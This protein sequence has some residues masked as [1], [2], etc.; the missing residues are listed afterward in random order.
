MDVPLP[1]LL[2]TELFEQSSVVAGMSGLNCVVTSINI[3]DG[4]YGYNY[5][6]KNMFVLCSAYS[7]AASA[8][9][10]VDLLEQLFRRGVVG[11]AIKPTYFENNAIPDALIRRADALGLPLVALSG[12]CCS[13]AEFITFFSNSVYLR[14]TR[15]IVSKNQLLKIL[16]QE[17]N[18]Q[19]I[20]G[21]VEKISGF[22]NRNVSV[23]FEDECY[24]FPRRS[25]SLPFDQALSD[26]S[27][28]QHFYSSPLFGGMLCYAD[29]PGGETTGH[30]D[31]LGVPIKAGKNNLD[32]IW[33]HGGETPCGGDDAATLDAA[34]LACELGVVQML[35]H[36]QQEARRR[37]VFVESLLAGKL[38]T[39]H[40]MLLMA[41]GVNWRLPLET[42]ILIV[43]C[44]DPAIDNQEIELELSEMF[45]R[46]TQNIIVYPYF[47][48]VIVFAP[49][50]DGADPAFFEN[51]LTRLVERFGR[52]CFR[53]GI[54]RETALKAAN[55]SYAQA[56]YAL[57]IG[58]SIFPERR[59]CFFEKLGIF[60]LYCP[61][62]LPDELRLFCQD[63]L[64]TL[65]HVDAN[66]KL[67]LVKTLEIFFHC[68]QNYSRTGNALYL[69]PN[70]IRYRMETIEKICGVD[71]NEPD[72]I[73]N[74]KT[75]LKLLPIL[76]QGI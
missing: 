6:K 26:C 24:A 55:K 10:Q 71:F 40:E 67:D 64:A 45:R 60:R 13:Y 27:S 63:Y 3:I 62:A 76:G 75:A 29:Q 37:L 30:N 36:Q 33:L 46:Q 68:Q 65:I 41:K 72:D 66:A 7:I 58:K 56:V 25:E 32:S 54:G 69:H 57:R 28:A 34:V 50:S 9:K 61:E 49:R 17:M 48:S 18:Q 16:V 53:L 47:E 39:L 23:L 4:V 1:I 22:L 20:L 21:L 2:Q 12:T 14:G 19:G 51:I 59:I 42:R 35:T 52:S 43:S 15:E 44:E 31:K 38:S 11:V 73:L 74:L 5:S 70:T 8:K